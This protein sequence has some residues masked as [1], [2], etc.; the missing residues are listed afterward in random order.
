[1]SM[2]FEIDAVRELLTN[3][4]MQVGPKREAASD[5][6]SFFKLVLTRV[7]M[8]CTHTGTEGC[9]TPPHS[10]ERSRCCEGII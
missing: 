7:A 8:F 6:S 10:V 9:E 5:A 4:K 2:K 3:L 1:M